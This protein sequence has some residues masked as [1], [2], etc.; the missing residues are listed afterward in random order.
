MDL[1]PQVREI[2]DEQL[3]AWDKAAYLAC[4]GTGRVQDCGGALVRYG[5]SDIKRGDLATEKAMFLTGLLP[6]QGERFYIPSMRLGEHVADLYANSNGGLEWVVLVDADP[7]EA[8][9]ALIRQE[10]NELRLLQEQ[11]TAVNELLEMENEK[12]ARATRM[13]SEFLANMSH[14]LRTPLT[15]ILGYAG[16]LLK[17][18][19]GELNE[20]QKRFVASMD[21]SGRH[22]LALINGILDLSRIEAGELELKWENFEISGVVKE[23]LALIEPQAATKRI[24]VESHLEDGAM[25]HADQTRFKQIL[26][27]LLS[28]AVKFTPEGGAVRLDCW[29]KDGFILTSVADTG[30]G[31][32]PA[33]QQRL[34]RDFFR[35]ASARNG[36]VDGTGLGLA[37]TKR[38]VER[39]GGTI[40]V[41]SE[42]NQG[43]CFTFS[44]Q[45]AKDRAG[46]LPDAKHVSDENTAP[47]YSRAGR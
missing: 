2:V 31:I 47:G 42:L 43:S 28:N 26:T 46:A 5:L 45:A 36:A 33:D 40:D 21:T 16:L 37:I 27:N 15:G 22:L 30:P 41:K 6:L 25:V 18:V 35:T 20:K 14:E 4:S 44:L 11:L 17:G 1:P 7:A 9:S 29:E 32:S 24:E 12:L 34:F 23:V 10:R 19:A 39:L 3:V 38:L 8:Q 13:K